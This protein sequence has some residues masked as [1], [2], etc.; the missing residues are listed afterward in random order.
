LSGRLEQF[1]RIAVWIFDLNLFAARTDFH[2]IA[3]A[4]SSVLE[5]TD[6]GRQFLH[7]KD[8]TIPPTRLLLAAIGQIPGA[9]RPRTAEY[10]LKI[11]DRNLPESG[12]VLPVQIETKYFGVKGNRALNILDL[13]PKAPKSFQEWLILCGIDSGFLAHKKILLLTFAG[14]SAQ[15]AEAIRPSF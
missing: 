12:Q 10:E 13:I 4:C 3:E 5:F 11:P 1:N 9:G 15:P 14:V 2:L 8:D 6:E 7:V